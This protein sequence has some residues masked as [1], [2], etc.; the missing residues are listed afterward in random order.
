MYTRLVGDGTLGSGWAADDGAA[1]HF[2]GRELAEVVVSTRGAAAYR[3]TRSGGT[4]QEQRLEGR[5][6]R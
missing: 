6:L 4:G 3:V 1:L 5:L 2:V